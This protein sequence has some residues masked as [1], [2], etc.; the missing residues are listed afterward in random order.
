MRRS[1]GFALAVGLAAALGLAVVS[2]APVVPIG[3]AI[4]ENAA[5]SA[6][7]GA[8]ISVIQSYVTWHNGLDGTF[9]F[10]LETAAYRDDPTEAL[11]D[12]S[13]RGV[14]AVVGFPLSLEALTAAS[15]ADRLKLPVIS[16]AASSSVLSGK[17]DWFFRVVEDSHGEGGQ[18][19][20]FLSGLGAKNVVIYRSPYNDAYINQLVGDMIE[21]S[22]LEVAGTAFY[23][24]GNAPLSGDA[25]LVAAEPSRTY[26]IVQDIAMNWPSVPV[27][28]ARW[29]Q[30]SDFS[31]ILNVPGADLYFSSNYDPSVI[32]EDP[33]TL[34]LSGERILD[35]GLFARHGAA[36]MAYLA[37]VLEEDPGA[38]G[39]SLRT[40]MKEPRS[41][42]GPGWSLRVDEFG[43]AWADLKFYSLSEGLVREIER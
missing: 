24:N 16:P 13:A 2:R 3:V 39:E 34:F 10:R 27:V 21:A 37:D 28:L 31:L 17:D 22:S 8:M 19:G 20:A 15:V 25:I 6:S 1:V 4:N 35:L 36:A 14:R 33:F 5:L 9:K 29:C 18:L 40:M 41:V 11:E 38:K 26:W 30:G 42:E 23:P 32:P 43:D 7:E 12:L